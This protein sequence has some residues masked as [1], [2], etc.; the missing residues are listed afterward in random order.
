M[1]LFFGKNQVCA[2]AELRRGMQQAESELF[3]P[4]FRNFSFVSSVFHALAAARKQS[5]A[6]LFCKMT[7]AKPAAH[8]AL[9]FCK[10]PHNLWMIIIKCKEITWIHWLEWS[11]LGRSVGRSVGQS[12]GQ[13]VSRLVGRR[14]VGGPPP[15]K[16][17]H[18]SNALHKSLI[19]M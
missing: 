4:C 3:L 16:A 19:P 7:C 8:K 6:L 12:F 17:P 11:N 18:L 13:L 1:C 9:L 14:S 5:R 2:H 10:L 15:H